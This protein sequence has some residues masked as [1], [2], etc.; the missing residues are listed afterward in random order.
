MERY[1]VALEIMVALKKNGGCYRDDM[2]L[3]CE[4]ALNGCTE[5]V[6]Q[7]GIFGVEIIKNFCEKETYISTEKILAICNAILGKE[8]TEDAD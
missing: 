5:D 7:R 8:V 3:I 6:D 2:E 1:K 4:T